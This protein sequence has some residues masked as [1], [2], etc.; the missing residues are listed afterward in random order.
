MLTE[1]NDRADVM[2]LSPIGIKEPPI[3]QRLSKGQ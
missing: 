1:T 2:G 3:R